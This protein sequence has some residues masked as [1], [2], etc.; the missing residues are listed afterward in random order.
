[1]TTCASFQI[2]SYM[3]RYYA[4]KNIWTPELHKSL[5]AVPEPINLVDKYAVCALRNETIVEYL[6]WEAMDVLRKQ[7]FNFT[8]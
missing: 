6:G 1:M 4:Y 3:K 8:S 7:S 5:K 2:D